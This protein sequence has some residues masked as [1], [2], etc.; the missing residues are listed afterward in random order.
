MK[1]ISKWDLQNEYNAT[2]G[3]YCITRDPANVDIEWIRKN[4]F[5]L[6][7]NLPTAI[8]ERSPQKKVT[9]A[10]IEAYVMRLF[11]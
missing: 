6:K 8:L 5:Q 7:D 3:L 4:A 1:N 11:L 2:R 9:D 10:R